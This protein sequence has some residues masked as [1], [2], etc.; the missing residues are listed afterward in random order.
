M[1]HGKHLKFPDDVSISDSAK[2][3]IRKLLSEPNARL[4]RK[5]VAAIKSHP[6]FQ[7]PNWNFENIQHG[8]HL[9][10]KYRKKNIYI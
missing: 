1:D 9:H 10:I 5:G 3:L 4:G 7:N 6:F 2:D 8:L